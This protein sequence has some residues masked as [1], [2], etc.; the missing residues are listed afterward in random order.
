[1]SST[2]SHQ[3]K[4]NSATAGAMAP[5]GARVAD[6]QVSQ[7]NETFDFDAWIKETP[8]LKYLAL[9]KGTSKVI[10]F[11]SGRPDEMLM[12]DFKGKLEQPVPVARYLVTTLEEPSEQLRFDVTSK[13][14]A[15]DINAY[16]VKDS[17]SLK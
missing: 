14:L 13:R 12:T 9:E 15:S 3:E 1:M 8:R 5:T 4:E 2:K 6:K 10:R 17:Q 16:F 7:N 11:K